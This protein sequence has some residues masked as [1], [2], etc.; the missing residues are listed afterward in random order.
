MG[1]MKKR[2]EFPSTKPVRRCALEVDFC[3]KLGLVVDNQW[4]FMS[5]LL[6]NWQM[7]YETE[8]FSHRDINLPFHLLQG[9]INQWRL[10][11]SLKRFLHRNEVVFF[12]WAG[13][14][15]VVTS[16]LKTSASIV[17]RL[18]SFELYA[19]APKIRW[20]TVEKIIL[21]SYA[22]QRRFCNLYPDMAE[23]TSVVYYGK[24]LEK[25]QFQEREFSGVIGMLCNLLP[26]KRVYEV[27]LALYELN[28][29][30]L[31]LFL[32]LAGSPGD[33][34]AAQRY[35]AAMQRLVSTLRLQDQILFEG[36]VSNPADFLSQ[37]DIFIS[38][39]YWE[40]QQNA[41]L[42]AMATGCYCISHFWD[43]AEEVLPPENLFISDKEMCHKI[44]TYC[45]LPNN[46]KGIHRER[47]RAVAEE[48][49]DIRN[50]SAAIC[51]ILEN[52]SGGLTSKWEKKR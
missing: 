30:G 32:R 41:L 52:T 38:N 11:R 14:L 8:V 4:T 6:A 18:H 24:P 17:V 43:G 44:V 28:R 22:M 5:D 29:M 19:Y 13:P 16:R 23:K 25:F 26:I 34:P 9:R 20:E 51:A 39:S 45:E 50:I 31:R 49:F 27:I 36:Y 1:N 33:T 7:Q 37:I 3:M 47:M 48:K 15:L 21:V 46:Q 42:E 40:G 10:K 2:R 12:E 35:Y